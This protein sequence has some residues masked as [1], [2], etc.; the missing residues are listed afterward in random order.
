MVAER[1]WISRAQRGA[2]A[3]LSTGSGGSGEPTVGRLV[4]LDGSY[5]DWFEGRCGFRETCLLAAIDD[6]TRA[7]LH[8]ALRRTTACSPKPRAMR[9]IEGGEATRS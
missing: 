5:H 3:Q 7:L 2:G 9:T 1:L 8:V 6:A 4:Q